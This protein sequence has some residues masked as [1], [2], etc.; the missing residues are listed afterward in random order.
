VTRIAFVARP[1][2]PLPDKGEWTFIT[3]PAR[4]HKR[5]GG[6]RARIPIAVH[7]GKA[8]FRT[9]A[10]PYAGTHQFMFNAQMRDASGKK[11]GDTFRIVIERDMR[12]RTVSVPPDL[13]RALAAAGLTKTFA[14]Y[15][16]SHRKAFVDAVTEAKRPETRITRI[17]GCL[18]MVREGKK[19]S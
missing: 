8:I 7:I 9:S 18:A 6:D 4:V 3:L 11:A 2:R 13:K 19:R 15:A 12:K 17:A 5:L 14:A 10:M 16:P 1:S